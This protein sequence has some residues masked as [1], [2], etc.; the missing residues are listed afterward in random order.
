MRTRDA[1]EIVE[2]GFDYRS[3]RLTLACPRCAARHAASLP[4][5]IMTVRPACPTCGY[6]AALEPQ[7]IADACARLMPPLPNAEAEAVDVA[8]GA[9]VRTWPAAVDGD[10]LLTHAGLDLGAG[11]GFALL[12]VVLCGYLAAAARERAS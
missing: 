9:L 2:I 11:A 6:D 12:P 4:S 1:Q 5:V 8:A 10:A 7:A 3:L